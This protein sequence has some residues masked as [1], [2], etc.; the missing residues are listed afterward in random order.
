M[1][2]AVEDVVSEAVARRL[3]TVIRPD[4]QITGVVR[5]NGKSYVRH[6]IRELNRAAR[7]VPVFV[8]IDL[9]TPV[10]CPADV[11]R[12]WLPTSFAPNLLFRVAV[13]EIESWIMADRIA[14]ATFF[15]V[16]LQRV[17][18][19]PDAILKPKEQIV[20]IARKSRRK[21]IRQDMVP[22]PGDTRVV[23]PAFNARLTAFVTDVWNPNMAVNASP[24]LRSAVTRLK[25]F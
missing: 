11:I 23:G 15:S 19:H 7:S 16:P 17:P 2:A 6:R 12:S 3:V 13:M 25:A 8:M 20:A 18:E 9:D 24:S 4:L 21:E 10:P 5:K 14:F 1:I 22:S